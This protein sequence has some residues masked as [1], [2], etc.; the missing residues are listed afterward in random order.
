MLTQFATEIRECTRGLSLSI[1][2]G[3]NE[4]YSLVLETLAQR[5]SS[6]GG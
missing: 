1:N 3:L 2:R 4:P 5:C 6:V